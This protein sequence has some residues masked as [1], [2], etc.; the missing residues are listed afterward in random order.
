MVV[1]IAVT[2]SAQVPFIGRTSQSNKVL[3]REN[4]GKSKRTGLH[5]KAPRRA[6]GELS[7]RSPKAKPS[8]MSAVDSRW[9]CRAPGRYLHP[10]GQEGAR[11]VMMGVV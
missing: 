11:Q 6:L 10:S 5:Q 2:A 9:C 3:K 1:A 4:V 7:P 8:N